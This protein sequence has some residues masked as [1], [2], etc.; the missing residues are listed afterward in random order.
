MAEKEADYIIDAI[1]NY[2]VQLPIAYDFEDASVKYA[3]KNGVKIT[4]ELATSFAKT[5]CDKIKSYGLT[6]ILYT[7]PSYL[8]TYYDSSVKEYPIW[9]ASW[10]SNPDFNNP[11]QSCSIWQYSSNGSVDGISTKVDMDICYN[12]YKVSEVKDSEELIAAKKLIVNGW[13]S[14]LISMAEK[15]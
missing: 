3:L 11:T 2:S 10:V 7:N 4:K 15:I 5:F 8:S 6:P 1:K 13:G 12:D 14:I 9:L